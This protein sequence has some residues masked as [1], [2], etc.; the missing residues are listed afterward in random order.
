[1]RYFRLSIVF[2]CI[3]STLSAFSQISHG[4]TPYFLQSSILRSASD[5]YFIEMPPFD[6]DSVLREDA[7]N[8]GNMRSSYPF[9][10]KFYTHID[11]NDATPAVLPDGTTVRQIGIHSA[12]AYSIN[13]L[14]NDFEIPQGG[15]LFVYNSDHSY[16]AGSFDY[17]NNSPDK[18]LPIQPVAGESIIVEYSEPA[19]VPFKGHFVISEVN[20]DY[21][22]IFKAGREPYPDGGGVSCMPDVLCSDA[23]GET[24]RST[25]M[26]I[27]NGSV[28]CT[29]S[30]LNNTSGDGKPY[31]LTAVH[32]FVDNENTT[33]PTDIN[34]YNARAATAIAFF[35][36]DRPVCDANIKMKGSEEMSL[37]GAAARAFVSRKDIALIEFSDSPPNY[38]NVYYAGWN[39]DLTGTGKHTNIHHPGG[40][41]KKYGMTDKAISLVTIYP[42]LFDSYSFWEI[43]SWKVGSTASGSSGSPLFDENN[44][45]IG[46]L[47]SGYSECSG[48]L[49]SPDSTKQTD[50]FAAL[51]KGWETADVTNQLKTYL[52][53]ENTGALQ[54]QGMDPNQANPLIRLGNASYTGG[55]SL[56]T[57][58][59]N[60][61]N[62]GYV[63]GNNGL[64]ATEFAEAFTVANPVE[65]FG[66]YLLIPA[67]TFSSSSLV[68]IYI[69]TGESSPE[70]RIDS[71][72][73]V[74]QY[75][76]YSA[77]GFSQVD[78]TFGSVPTENFVKFNNPVTVTANKF[79]ISYSINST[80]TQFYVYNT[81]FQDVSQSN[82]A[83]VKDATKGWVTADAYDGFKPAK[84]SLAIQPLL[85]SWNGDQLETIQGSNNN[86]FYYERSGRILTLK[87]PLNTQGQAA[88]YSVSGQLLEKISI[89]PR[90][91]T[92]VLR[93]RPKGTVGI[94]KITSNIS[95]CVGKFIY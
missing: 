6:L 38:Y 83:W 18:I 69:Y 91:T 94:V 58:K 78:K 68:T 39:R 19:N 36:Y 74:P 24:A 34:F 82:T 75:I 33:F 87:E 16:V 41:L 80:S 12:G 44:F 29:G 65:I 73:F 32:C 56:I 7:I 79:Y 2:L 46:G 84:T 25:V 21:R 70:I 63:F 72:R 40:A 37:A 90:Q 66:A 8:E 95:S 61:P 20:H 51:G 35:N 5:T 14:L 47:T 3:I 52:D 86:G 17:R 93:E 1:M 88:V 31:V 15:K 45:V 49:P 53:P 55:D 59:L 54:Y 67:M 81:K 9:A 43:P 60:P 42:T 85:R 22:D 76:S 13:L 71:A 23:T 92:V 64:Q 62:N 30:L 48:L 89:Q 77:G 10:Y 11:L 26:L 28:A 50:F 4:G 57:S 27:I